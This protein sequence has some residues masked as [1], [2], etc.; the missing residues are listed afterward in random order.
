MDG[1]LRF[2]NKVKANMCR[3][4]SLSSVKRCWSRK[5]RA[6]QVQVHRNEIVRCT[7]IILLE[8][9]SCIVHL[10]ASGSGVVIRGEDARESSNKR[11]EEE[12]RRRWNLELD[13]FK[14]G[15]T[16]RSSWMTRWL[17]VTSSGWF[18]SIPPRM[19]ILLF[20]LYSSCKNSPYAFCLIVVPRQSLTP[21]WVRATPSPF[22]IAPGGG[23]CLSSLMMP[24]WQSTFRHLYNSKAIA[25]LK[26]GI[27]FQFWNSRSLKPSV[28]EGEADID[29]SNKKAE[30]LDYWEG[31]V[32]KH[33]KKE[34]GPIS[35]DTLKA[36]CRF[37]FSLESNPF[38][39]TVWDK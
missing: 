4:V 15:S 38:V 5:C 35:K 10:L 17:L 1:D 34:V 27:P 16:L 29:L 31:H 2:L 25:K 9:V 13:I 8:L 20:S 11:S 32:P 36:K 30:I 39:P 7:M 37:A 14:F 33:K 23:G 6:F 12:K 19:E 28:F 3:L 21:C 18:V 24:R 26:Y 22:S